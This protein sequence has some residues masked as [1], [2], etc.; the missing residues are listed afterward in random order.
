MFLFLLYFC[1]YTWISLCLYKYTTSLFCPSSSCSFFLF[2][3]PPQWYIPL[4]HYLSLSSKH[5]SFHTVFHYSFSCLFLLFT[6]CIPL[7]LLCCTFQFHFLY[8][9]S[10]PCSFLPSFLPSTLF[11]P[12]LFLSPSSVFFTLTEFS[13]FSVIHPLFSSYFMIHIHVLFS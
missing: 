6:S 4:F 5:S 9:L 3:S 7:T 8:C 1:T 12:L 11:D 13:T 10:S 2:T